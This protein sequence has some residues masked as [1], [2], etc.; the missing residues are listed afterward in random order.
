MK[1][2]M[3]LRNLIINDAI[4]REAYGADIRIRDGKIA[5]IG[6]GLMPGPGEEAADFSGLYAYPGFVEAHSHIT[7]SNWGGPTGGQ[8]DVNEKSSTMTP[9]VRAMDAF[10]PQDPAVGLAVKGGITTVCACP[11]SSN[12]IGGSCAAIKLHGNCVDDMVLK[13]VAA[14]KCAFGENVKSSYAGKN[15]GTRMAIAARLREEL[16]KTREYMEKKEAAPEGKKPPFDMK[17]EAMIPVLRGEIPLKCH[18][19]RADDILTA[20]RI[21]G[22]FGVRITIEHCTEGHLIVGELK[23]AGVPVACGPL[24][25]GASK[26]EL[27]NRTVETPGILAAA[28]VPV[29]II[30]DAPVNMQQYLPLC[31]ALAV[32]E[33]MDP[34]AALQAITINAAKHIGVGDRVGSLEVGKDAD[35]VITDGNP[36]SCDKVIRRVYINGE[37]VYK[38]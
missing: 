5:Q 24:M 8:Q 32:R 20:I 22:E 13:P 3:L 37:T 14:M 7:L 17:L 31:A 10:N 12:V 15:G 27:R 35:I 16:Y 21:A 28:G 11:G 2:A 34:F 19:H 26:Q 33:G 4:H 30:T 38:D 18:A 23:R 29:T 1:T 36:L 25:G 9:E 6:A